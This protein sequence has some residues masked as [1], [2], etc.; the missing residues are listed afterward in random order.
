MQ[1]LIGNEVLDISVHEAHHDQSHLFLRHGK[2][3]LLYSISS[4]TSCF[5]HQRLVLLAL[6]ISNFDAGNSTITRKAIAQNAIYAILLVFEVTSL[7][8]CPG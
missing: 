2:V 6:L 8:N 3:S 4:T 7:I 5:N 1:L